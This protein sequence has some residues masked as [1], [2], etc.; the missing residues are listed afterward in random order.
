MSSA[1]LLIKLAA[2][3]ALA[4]VSLSS[5]AAEDDDAATLT[6]LMVELMP[7]GKVFD[8]VAAT[9]PSWPAQGLLDKVSTGQLACLRS[10]LS[11][12]GYRKFTRAR[13]TEYIAADPA[14]IDGDIDVL[15]K[16]AAELFGKLILAGVEGERTGVAADP[17]A[18]L[19]GA[20]EEQM[21]AFM[22]LFGDAKFAP[23]RELA[24]VGNQLNTGATAEES[25]KAG[26]QLGQVL[27]L[28]LMNAAMDTCGVDLQNGN[29]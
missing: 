9:D 17:E 26:E 25:E 21:I 8:G 14:R 12:E 5:V 27:T 18:V 2:S 11:S 3:L 4:A 6:D 13:V 22:A 10:E 20:T 23:L 24:G 28:K 1:P 19:A 7:F 16:G 29:P 15:E